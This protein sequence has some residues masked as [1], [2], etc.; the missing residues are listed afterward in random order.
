M[1][2][3][4]SFISIEK[5]ESRIFAGLF[6]SSGCRLSTCRTDHYLERGFRSFEFYYKLVARDLV[7][8]VDYSLPQ[9]QTMILDPKKEKSKN[10][11]ES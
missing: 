5:R 8:S 4:V 1:N 11:F 7:Q 3:L 2:M 6:W 9:L 10:D